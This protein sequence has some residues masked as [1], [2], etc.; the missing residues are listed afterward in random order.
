MKQTIVDDLHG[1]SLYD[2]L[3][4][5]ENNL[6]VEGFLSKD[7]NYNIELIT[8]NGKIK[9]SVVEYCAMQNIYCKE[10]LGNSGVLIIYPNR[11]FNAK[12]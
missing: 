11:D 12:N 5:L 9:T 1:Y 10:K 7:V 3:I 8:G 6:L 4:H 2:A